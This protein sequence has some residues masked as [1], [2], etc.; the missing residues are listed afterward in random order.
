M[1]LTALRSELTTGHPDTGAYSGDDTT[2]AGELNALNRTKPRISVTGSE[3]LNAID[4]TEFLAKTEAERQRVW[5]IL[6]LGTLNPFGMEAILLVGIFGGG[7]ATI[8]ALAEIRLE[9]ISRA[10]ELGLEKV[11]GGHVQRARA[12]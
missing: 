7:S 1:D 12:G 5:N 9:D 8:T 11:N 3:V 2:A 4:Q 6:H 10:E